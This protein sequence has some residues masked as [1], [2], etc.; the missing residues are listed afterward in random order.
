MNLELDIEILG[1]LLVGLAVAELVPVA[2]A[3]GYGEPALP[4]LA[5]AIVALVFGLPIVLSHRAADR[6]LHP[7]D[8]FLVVG[9]AWIV[10]SVFGA[11][12][13]VLEGT[14][15]LVDAL[16]ESVAA[17][18]YGARRGCFGS[19]PEPGNV[20]SLSKQQPNARGDGALSRNA[21]QLDGRRRASTNSC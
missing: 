14:L 11:L 1:W 5:S 10:A 6:Q 21:T 13:Y 18:T 19:Q 12:P 15:G 17:Q 20:L 2:T 9:G 7:R 3:L 8:G 16:F 4:Y